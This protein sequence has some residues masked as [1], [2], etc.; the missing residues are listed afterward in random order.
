M[1]RPVILIV[2]DD[3]GVRESYAY[4]LEDAG[5]DTI[6]ADSRKDALRQLRQNSCHVALLDMKM[7][8]ESDGILLNQTIRETFPDVETIIV[9]AYAG[10]TSAVKALKDGAVDYL[11]KASS[12]DEILRAIR[13]ALH[14]R[15]ERLASREPEDSQPEI[16]LGLICNH[17]FLREGMLHFTDQN[18]VY[19]LK[20][21]FRHFQELTVS[22]DIDPVDI[23]LICASCNFPT[24]A[25]AG[26]ALER[27]HLIMPDTIP[28]LLHHQYSLEERAALLE[29]GVKGFL[30]D[31]LDEDSLLHA[32][33]RLM[34]GEV[35]AGRAEVSMVLN[36]I[37]SQPA[38]QGESG[39]GIGPDLG[40]LTPR[41]RDVLRLLALDF[42]NKEIAE[43]LGVSERT[44]K[45]HLYNVYQKM[46]VHTR[47]EAVQQAYRRHILP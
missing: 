35:W 10:Y 5:Y 24:F 20:Q 33:N 41:E 27:L 43:K 38:S 17:T 22:R 21:H 11:S 47:T 46:G 7:E 3:P 44:V 39:E 15:R 25:S 23:M 18:P 32:L 34:A 26:S 6:Q 40:G 28:V 42:P 12:N 29:L 14:R 30:A 1:E 16:L 4:F 37:R 31:E 19:H 45:T 2:D 36:R 13:Q 9:T 8:G